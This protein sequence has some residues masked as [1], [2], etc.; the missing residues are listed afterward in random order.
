M[1]IYQQHPKLGTNQPG[2]QRGVVLV[3]SLLLLLIVTMLGV[4]SF[5][6]ILLQE[7][8]SSNFRT[9]TLTFE[10]ANSLVQELWPALMDL[11]AGEGIT[12]IRTRDAADTYDLDWNDDGTVDLDLTAAASICY[13]GLGIAPGTDL[14]YSAYL[15]EMTANAS[16]PN[17]AASSVRQGGYIVAE[18]TEFVLPPTCP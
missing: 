14:D 9:K 11:E 4:S 12:D 1:R 15:F 3:A 5:R 10:T 16:E 7:K 18:A 13:R 8:M 6:D 17:G 2:K